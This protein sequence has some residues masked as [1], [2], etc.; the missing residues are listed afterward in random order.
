[1]TVRVQHCCASC[2]SP[3]L[4]ILLATFERLAVGLPRP[5]YGS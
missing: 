5:H 2:G 4:L 1:M 3:L